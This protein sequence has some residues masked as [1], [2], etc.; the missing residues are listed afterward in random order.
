MPLSWFFFFQPDDVKMLPVISRYGIWKEVKFM[1][2]KS[3]AIQHFR[4]REPLL[5]KVVGPLLYNEAFSRFLPALRDLPGTCLCLDPVEVM[6]EED[7]VEAQRSRHILQLIG[8][9]SP[10][11]AELE[12]ALSFYS[13]TKYQDVD[14]AILK[15]LG[16]TYW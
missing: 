4:E 11:L 10:N 6:Q 14:N 5:A 3:V 8:A 2:N 9:A 1:A 13:Y 7:E 16:W 12:K 15:V